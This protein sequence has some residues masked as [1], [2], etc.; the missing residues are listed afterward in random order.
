MNNTTTQTANNT[1]FDWNNSTA[2]IKSEYNT[3]TN[4]GEESVDM[5][6]KAFVL[7][8]DATLVALPIALA[9]NIYF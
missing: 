4:I 9:Y 3:N 8:F 2:V 7:L 6:K 1:F 5:K